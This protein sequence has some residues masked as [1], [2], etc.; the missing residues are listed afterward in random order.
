MKK[1][2]Y[3]GVDLNR[4]GACSQDLKKKR[5]IKSNP[6]VKGFLSKK[7]WAI[8]FEIIKSRGLMPMYVIKSKETCFRSLDIYHLKI[9]NLRI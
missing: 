9:Y 5:S 6:N 2:G 3:V 4:F 1:I 7:S 8:G